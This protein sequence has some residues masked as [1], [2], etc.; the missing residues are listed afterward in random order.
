MM[1]R[2]KRLE[3]LKDVSKFYKVEMATCEP[4]IT[5]NCYMGPNFNTL[6][7]F[8]DINSYD[9][10]SDYYIVRFPEPYENHTIMSIFRCGY[11]D[12]SFFK[13]YFWRITP[14]WFKR[15]YGVYALDP[16]RKDIMEFAEKYP[17][18]FPTVI[19]DVRDI[20]KVWFDDYY[21]KRILKGI[22][23][24]RQ[25]RLNYLVHKAWH[26]YWYD[27]RDEKGHSRVC[28]Y[29]AKQLIAE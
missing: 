18:L 12:Y 22:E 21:S 20:E 6:G 27:Q 13:E 23:L 17:S 3:V 24:L 5:Y 11:D 15:K 29:I 7:E 14:M 16:L 10:I 26:F 19:N 4:I 28:K 25:L 1:D 2:D 8:K 9:Y